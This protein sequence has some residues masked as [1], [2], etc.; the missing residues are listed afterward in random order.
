MS[1][2]EYIASGVLELYAAGGLIQAE[3]EEVELR[4]ASSP[5]VRAALDEACSAM[6]YYAQVHAVPPR[7]ELKNRI[8]S[9][10]QP[11]EGSGATTT[12][13]EEDP[14]TV[15]YTLPLE[16]ETSPYKWMFAA[17][18][19][20]FLI[21]GMLS[22]HFYTK[23][24]D[25]EQRLAT[26]VSSEQLLAQNMQNTS[27]RTQQLEQV[28]AILRDP[29]YQSVKLQGVKA[30]PGA[31][32][33]VYWHPQKQEVYIDKVSLPAPPSGMQYQLW[34]L[35][36]GTPVDAGLIPTSGNQVTMLK[37]KPI[38]SAQAFAVTLEP[39]GGS[40]NPTLEQL[41]VMGKIEA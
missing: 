32:A 41:T 22:Y 14:E 24:Q 2:E 18:I 23:W 10:L 29:S 13:F 20:L 16:E 17:S 39:E 15:S 27:L 11:I 31:N 5:E 40:V 38:K 34:A 37:M 36:E 19:V 35:D 21:S 6:E 7:P 4:A 30:H 26:A 8:L 1:N 9:R 3:R 12:A 25:A 28:L 33:I